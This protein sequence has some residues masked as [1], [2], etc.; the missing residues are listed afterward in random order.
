MQR[1]TLG[2]WMGR[3][4]G[5]KRYHTDGFQYQKRP[6]FRCIHHPNSGLINKNDRLHISGT[7]P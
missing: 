4:E 2:I 3:I 7:E 6:Q 5:I 1:S